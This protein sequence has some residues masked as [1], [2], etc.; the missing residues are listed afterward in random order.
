MRMTKKEKIVGRVL[1]LC[2]TLFAVI[3]AANMTVGVILYAVQQDNKRY[4]QVCAATVGWNDALT[5]AYN[6]ADEWI[7]CSD[8]LTVQ[9]CRIYTGGPVGACSLIA[10]IIAMRLVNKMLNIAKADIRY[11]VRKRR[12]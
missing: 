6:E 9:A 7:K 11:F 10:M 8:R 1:W 5:D 12:E 2:I 4:A 3:V